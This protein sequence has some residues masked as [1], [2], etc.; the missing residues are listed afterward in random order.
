M[1]KKSYA[2][3]NS[4]TVCLNTIILTTLGRNREHPIQQNFILT[5]V[6]ECL[7]VERREALHT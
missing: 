4:E 5:I 7:S 1:S 3:L 2:S 6:D